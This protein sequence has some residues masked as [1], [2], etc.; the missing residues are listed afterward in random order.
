MNVIVMNAQFAAKRALWAVDDWFKRVFKEQAGGAEI[1]ATL[2]IV[3]IVL[4]LA[5]IFRT[6]L[7]NLVKNLWDKLVFNGDTSNKNSNDVAVAWGEAG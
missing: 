7:V 6:Q 1:V 3:G 2:V 4:A 5:L